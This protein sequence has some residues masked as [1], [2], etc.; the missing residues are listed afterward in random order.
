MTR[1]NVLSPSLLLTT[2]LLT[3]LLLPHYYLLL[4]SLLVKTLSG[5]PQE[6]QKRVESRGILLFIHTCRQGRKERSDEKE[7]AISPLA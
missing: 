5:I 2:P 1:T 6:E 4:L 3:T 7:E